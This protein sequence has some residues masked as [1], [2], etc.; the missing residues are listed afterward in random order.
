MKQAT[1]WKLE[2]AIQ[3]FYVGNEGGP[4]GSSSTPVENPNLL[5]QNSV[6]V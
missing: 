6:Y 2:E 4:V 3:L 1:G 5:D